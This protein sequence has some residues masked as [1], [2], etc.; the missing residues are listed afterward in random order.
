MNDKAPKDQIQSLREL[1][2]LVQLLNDIQ[3]LDNKF[4]NDKF[5]LE[6]E[7]EQNNPQNLEQSVTG[8]DDFT[9]TVDAF[10]EYHSLMKRL[11]V[12]RQ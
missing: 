9:V 2:E 11:G 7:Q 8:D 1:V 4:R 5:D 6:G 10:R 3:R 12:Y